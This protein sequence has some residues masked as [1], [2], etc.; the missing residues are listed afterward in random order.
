MESS[1]FNHA[2]AARKMTEQTSSKIGVPEALKVAS[3]VIGLRLTVDQGF[4]I[5]KTSGLSTGLH[6][7]YICDMYGFHYLLIPGGMDMKMSPHIIYT[8]SIGKHMRIN[9]N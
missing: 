8:Q 1:I 5:T 6:G 7:S 2:R 4:D 9:T 3:Q